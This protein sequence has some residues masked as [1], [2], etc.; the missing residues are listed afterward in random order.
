VTESAE[1][2]TNLLPSSSSR[3][4]AEGLGSTDTWAPRTVL[5][6]RQVDDQAAVLFEDIQG[7]VGDRSQF[8]VVPHLHSVASFYEHLATKLA[9]PSDRHLNDEMLARSVTAKLNILREA[10]RRVVLAMPEADYADHTILDAA[11]T[12]AQY[13]GVILVLWGDWESDRWALN[14]AVGRDLE[15]IEIPLHPLLDANNESTALLDEAANPIN[16]EGR[17]SAQD[18]ILHSEPK[19]ANPNG[20]VLGGITTFLII[21][22]FTIGSSGHRGDNEQTNTIVSVPLS[23]VPKPEPIVLRNTAPASKPRTSNSKQAQSSEPNPG[24]TIESHD[25]VPSIARVQSKRENRAKAAGAYTIQLAAFASTAN[26]DR[27][28]AR[29]PSDKNLE[30][31]RQTEGGRVL[32]VITY[33][34]YASFAE[35]NQAVQNIPL[36]LVE[37]RPQPRLYSPSPTS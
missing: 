22:V 17:L 4:H 37:G 3:R 28:L 21:V 34:R 19:P 8:I 23:A 18:A 36:E 26:R 2:F 13:S 16:S 7:I 33:G 12:L 6:V 29:L 30:V 5:M 20:W 15:L 24:S 31:T 11:M 32:F 14:S 35:A 27:F 1:I 9:A 10:N 25:E